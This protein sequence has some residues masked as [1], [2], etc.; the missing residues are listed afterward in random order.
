MVLHT[1]Q[2]PKKGEI[3]AERQTHECVMLADVS[4]PR[5]THADHGRRLEETQAGHRGLEA[6]EIIVR[7]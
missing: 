4:P 3:D 2:E 1:G 7:G 6:G 5:K